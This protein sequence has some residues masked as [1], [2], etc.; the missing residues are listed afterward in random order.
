LLDLSEEGAGLQMREDLWNLSSLGANVELR[1]V[2]PDT[3]R[4]IKLPARIT[5]ARRAGGRVRIG[6][7]FDMRRL[8]GSPQY[9]KVKEYLAARQIELRELLPSHG[10]KT[11]SVRKQA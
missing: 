5:H 1:L 8:A 4:T 6:L 9:R 2:L 11:G 10:K 7:Q 3:E